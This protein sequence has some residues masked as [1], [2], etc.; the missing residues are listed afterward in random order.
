MRAI[1]YDPSDGT[2][3]Q[4]KL[5]RSG[6]AVVMTEAHEDVTEMCLR[7]VTALLLD[8]GD[9]PMTLNGRAMRLTLKKERKG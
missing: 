7:A 9:V 1:A 6:D 5:R 2:I 4:C 3:R 8:K